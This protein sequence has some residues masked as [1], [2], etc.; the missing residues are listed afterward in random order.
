MTAWIDDQ[1]ANGRREIG[2]RLREARRKANLTQSEVAQEI[3]RTETTISRWET[4]RNQPT[5]DILQALARLYEAPL[6]RFLL[7]PSPEDIDFGDFFR[8]ARHCV[9]LS[10]AEVAAALGI[11]FEV[12]AAWE[13]GALS[14]S[15][16]DCFQQLLNLY[17]ISESEFEAGDYGYPNRT[18]LS[19][20]E[21][22]GRLGS[23][24][25][26]IRLGVGMPKEAAADYMRVAVAVITRIENGTFTPTP[27]F[28][29]LLTEELYGTIELNDWI[30]SKG[31]W[32][33]T[34]LYSLEQLD[35]EAT[36]SGH[37][38][39]NRR[40]VEVLEVASAAGGGAAVYDET[41]VGL[42]WFR[43]DWL[44]R[45]AIDPGQSNIISVRGASMEPTLPDG[46]SILLDRKRREPHEGRIYVMRTEEGLVVKRLDRDDM[47]RWTMLS[48][49][50]DWEPALLTYGSEII[51]E[52]RWAARTF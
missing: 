25:K 16:L 11:E 40:P 50:P 52:V 45:H 13:S 1:E 35:K 44:Q 51:G 30:D 26:E 49:N 33:T 20:P 48:D 37:I 12:V 5:A 29:E 42:L 6:F 10:Q 24:L 36:T 7:V 9:E 43:N 14:P 17:G 27:R 8:E 39:S 22:Y 34:R 38:A 2:R 18:M 4:G 23:K 28:L 47:G 3:G 19:D 41:P 32:P 21:F 15:Q 46:C 31:G